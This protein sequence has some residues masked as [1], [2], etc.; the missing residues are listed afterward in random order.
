MLMA[1]EKSDIRH[2]ADLSRIRLTD[3]EVD[4]IQSELP[5]ILHF[6]AELESAPTE[7]IEPVTGGIDL[8]NVFRADDG[9]ISALGSPEELAS[10]FLNKDVNG[11]LVVPQVFES[12]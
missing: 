2:L 1:L 7:N 6:I 3:D 11:A 9:S 5:S 8:V 10:S 12:R 4:A